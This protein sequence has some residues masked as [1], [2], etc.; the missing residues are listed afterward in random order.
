MITNNQDVLDAIPSD[1][2]FDRGLIDKHIRHAEYRHV[3]P[4]LGDTYYDALVTAAAGDAD[5]NLTSHNK[6]FWDEWLKDICGYAVLYEAY[7]YIANK[8]H[9]NGIV[10][11]SAQ[12][13]EGLR[14]SELKYFRAQIIDRL[15][16]LIVLADEWL[17]DRKANYPDYKGNND[18]D[19]E[20][21]GDLY[22]EDLGILGLI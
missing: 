14:P 11:T 9:S 17:T 21:R 15:K 1:S 8:I 18:D 12:N 2:H 22:S 20:E 13:A 3:K 10:N 19:C 6:T 7:P 5:T 16:N 4:F